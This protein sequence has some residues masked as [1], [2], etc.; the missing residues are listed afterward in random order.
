MAASPVEEV[1]ARVDLVDLIGS[2]V[3]LRQAGR[4]YRA[5]CPFHSEKTPSF[6]VFP[7]T[8]T[9]KCFGC[10]AGG[11][12]FSFVMQRDNL[13]FG[14]A[15]RELAA[16]AG[17]TL[18]SHGD[19]ARQEADDRLRRAN[20]AAALYYHALLMQQ[21]AGQAARRYVEGRGITAETCERFTLGYAPDGGSALRE[22]LAG[23]GFTT[24]DLLAAGLVVEREE[25]SGV[26]RDR[27]RHRL[28]FPIRDAQGRTIGFG[29]RTLTPDGVPKYLNSPQTALFEKGS[30]LYALDQAREAIRAERRAVI[31]EGY[32]DA[33][34]AHQGGFR[35]VV[36]ALG[37]ALGERQLGP[38]GR[39]SDEIVFALDPDAAGDSAT[40]RSLVVA[41]EALAS[42]V[43]VPTRRGIRYQATA[44]CTLRVAQLPDGKDPDELI[45]ADPARWR[46]LIATAPPVL[47]FL[48]ER[49]P[50]Q[51]DLASPQGKTAAV[52][53][54]VPALRDLADPIERAHYVQ[55]LARVVGVPEA[56]IAELTRPAM[57]RAQAAPPTLEAKADALEEY[58]LALV[59]LEVPIGSLSESD[60]ARP[61]SR[62]LLAWLRAGGASEPPPG[63]E[64]AWATVQALREQHAGEPPDR[65]RAEL[66]NTT[67]ELRK[68]RLT[69]EKQELDSIV[70][71]QN[72]ELP[73]E[74]TA[75]LVELMEQWAIL[76]RA[77]AAHGRV[78]AS[79]RRF[80]MVKGESRE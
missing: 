15:L 58:A 75:R 7:E 64:G 20:E 11:D 51:H 10:G 60:F 48:F 59:A 24:E 70:R 30:V 17:V 33:V 77:Q 71:D 80:Q 5:L 49:L 50:Y 73:R 63:L 2:T 74:L 66:D 8:Q 78:V 41:R 55:R 32:L 29:G 38:L 22:H 6:Y 31:V 44:R 69:R 34:M 4:S 65:L 3:A 79:P 26:V 16:R 68:R 13:E 25:G 1:K 12:A 35:N 40:L 61:E 46:E 36:A 37:T 67:L 57:R 72:G 76:E 45:R 21:P 19:P 27:F 52:E 53:E 9:W 43:P 39:I 56:A 14:E 47:D 54:L 18:E 42:T 23:A 62:G 28:M